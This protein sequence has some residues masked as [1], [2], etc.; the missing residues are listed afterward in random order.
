MKSISTKEIVI[1]IAILGIICF[2]IYKHQ[3]SPGKSVMFSGSTIELGYENNADQIVYLTESPGIWNDLAALIK[4]K[5]LSGVA[6]LMKSGDCFTVPA[7]TRAVYIESDAGSNY[8]I[9][10]VKIMD[11]NNRVGYALASNVR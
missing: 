2:T 7:G 3:T 8:H 9:C 1:A 11:G 10:R 6:S 5:D 4:A